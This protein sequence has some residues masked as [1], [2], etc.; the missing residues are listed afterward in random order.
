MVLADHRV[1][2]LTLVVTQF[3]LR[4][5]SSAYGAFDQSRSISYDCRERV[6]VDIRDVPTFGETE[7]S[8]EYSVRLRL[9]HLYYS[10]EVRPKIRQCSVPWFTSYLTHFLSEIPIFNGN[11]RTI[12]AKYPCMANVCVKFRS[13]CDGGKPAEKSTCES[14]TFQPD[15]IEHRVL[16]PGQDVGRQNYFR[17]YL[18]YYATCRQR[19]T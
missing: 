18:N 7:Y 13:L 8:A 1:L 12:L 3:Q 4:S 2:F 9:G 6:C 19:R 10:A 14:I 17:S 15:S 5:I 11:L 16:M